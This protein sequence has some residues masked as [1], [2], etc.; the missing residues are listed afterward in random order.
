MQPGV[1][2]QNVDDVAGPSTRDETTQDEE[3]AARKTPHVKV[4]ISNIIFFFFRLE[5]PKKDRTGKKKKQKVAKVAKVAAAPVYDDTF[6]K[7]LEKKC[8]VEF[9]FRGINYSVG[10]HVEKLREKSPVFQA[11]FEHNLKEVKTGRVLN[12]NIL[13]EIFKELL[14]YVYS[15]KLS[16]PLNEGLV[17]P[18]YIIAVKYRIEE[19]EKECL[20]YMCRIMKD[21]NVVKMFAFFLSHTFPDA[22]V[23]KMTGKCE[24]FILQNRSRMARY[25]MGHA[26][27]KVIASC[28]SFKNE[29]PT[30]QKQP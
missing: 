7:L 12:E 21:H 22:D 11:M 23:I 3:D 4:A 6:E 19:L 15:D 25:C 30:V 20:R 16:I 13:P 9:F 5:E 2:E 1:D 24:R 26:W 29:K 10:S 8:D 28:E 17:Q 27:D 18:L 14:H